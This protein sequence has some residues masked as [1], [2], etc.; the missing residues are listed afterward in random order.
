[1]PG[2]TE[3]AQI[4]SQFYLGSLFS[5]LNPMNWLS[6][7]N[8]ANWNF[9]S[10]LMWGGILAGGAALFGM[11]TDR[12]RNM[13]GDFIGG[14]SPEWQSRLAG[15]GQSLGMVPRGIDPET[16]PRLMAIAREHGVSP[17]GGVRGF[18]QPGL[19]YDLMIR[20]PAAVLGLARNMDRT[21]AQ[22]PET[23]RLAMQSVRTIIND[24][25][26]LRTLLSPEHKAHTYAL[27]E[28]LSPV[29]FQPGALGQFIESTAMRNGQINP[30][31]VQLLNTVL[32]DG[33]LME[34]LNPQQISAFFRDQANVQAFG[35]LLQQVDEARLPAAQRPALA[36]LRS[37]WGN[38]NEGVA[39]VLADRDSLQFLLHPPAPTAVSRVAGMLP[40]SVQTTIGSVLPSGVTGVPEKVGENLAHLMAV[41]TAFQQAGVEIGTGTAPTAS[42]PGTGARIQ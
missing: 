20:E 40:Q 5:W 17:T 39:E 14:L 37:H 23:T 3:N 30:A 35:R 18:L 32:G 41:R 38:L 24:P 1:M 42:R 12:G 34:R 9:G 29:P 27:L 13:I 15:W 36:A 4:P 26:R 7:L 31:F 10:I 11:F 21:Q 2:E 16:A 25:E 22:D 33:P 19:M 6:W 28:T 8:P